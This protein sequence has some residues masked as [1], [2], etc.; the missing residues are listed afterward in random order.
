MT[1]IK[2]YI[3]KVQKNVNTRILCDIVIWYW[4]VS[5]YLDTSKNLDTMKIK[6][7]YRYGVYIYYV[8]I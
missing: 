3:I 4:L 5:Y 8:S 1:K 2:S 7:Y 6:R